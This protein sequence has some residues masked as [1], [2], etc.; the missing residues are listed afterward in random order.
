LPAD[1]TAAAQQITAAVTTL[2]ILEV[3]RKEN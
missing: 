3:A 1:P 2:T